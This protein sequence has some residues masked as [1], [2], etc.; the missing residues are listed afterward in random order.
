MRGS[1]QRAGAFRSGATR[2]RGP[3]ERG[4]LRPRRSAPSRAPCSARYGPRKRCVA[5][6]GGSIR[7]PPAPERGERCPPRYLRAPPPPAAGAA[8]TAAAF[9]PLFASRLHEQDNMAPAGAAPE[10]E[11][12]TALTRA[13]RTRTPL[14]AI[15]AKGRQAER[16]G[17]LSAA[18]LGRRRAAAIFSEG[19]T[20][21]PAARRSPWQ[22]GWW[23][24]RPMGEPSGIRGESA[25]VFWGWEGDRTFFV[26]LRDGPVG[27]RRSA[28]L[29]MPSALRYSAGAQSCA[30]EL[31][32]VMSRGHK[33]LEINALLFPKSGTASS[34]FV[35]QMCLRLQR[36]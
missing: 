6:G 36:M 1:A 9:S 18:C 12:V 2:G 14:A 34:C 25:V 22:P 20:L 30:L 19:S 35:P 29:S 7:H 15:F 5:E 33:I 16:R 13:G 17:P 21:F 3:S 11:R 24:E 10:A 8:V 23:A 4:K 26:L 27:S 32:W 28:T 31:E